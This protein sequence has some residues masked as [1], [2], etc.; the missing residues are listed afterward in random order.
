[1]VKGDL[2]CEKVGGDNG[3]D[4]GSRGGWMVGCHG[5]HMGGMEGGHWG[6]ARGGEWVGCGWCLWEAAHPMAVRTVAMAGDDECVVVVHMKVS[7]RE[8][9]GTPVIAELS[10]R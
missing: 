8:G 6:G 4:R 1:V 9:G 7:G 3:V 5:G 10:N 2:V